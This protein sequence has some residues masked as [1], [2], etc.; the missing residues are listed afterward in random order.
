M[1]RDTKPHRAILDA[2]YGALFFGVPNEGMDIKSLAA[3]VKDQP[4]QA[5]LHS[6][7]KGSQ[8]LRNQSREFPKA[9]DYE[10]SEIVCFY[11]TTMSPTAKWVSITRHSSGLDK[12]SHD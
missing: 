12:Y 1:K 11:E 3:M 5:L 7:G 4:N 9:F 6:L 8:L 2:T 10:D